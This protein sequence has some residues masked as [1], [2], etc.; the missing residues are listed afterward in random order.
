M[1]AANGILMMYYTDN[2]FHNGTYTDNVWLATSSYLT[3]FQKWGVIMGLGPEVCLK[4]H[5]NNEGANLN[6]TSFFLFS[7]YNFYNIFY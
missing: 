2:G 6:P 4:E 3:G 7:I 5:K 1:V